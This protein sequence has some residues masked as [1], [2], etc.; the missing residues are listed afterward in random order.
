MTA[1]PLNSE[2]ANL[3]KR[4][5]HRLHRSTWIVI[6][7]LTIVFVL[8]EIP[9]TLRRVIHSMGNKPSSTNL[10]QFFE[11][12]WPCIFFDRKMIST[13]KYSNLSVDQFFDLEEFDEAP[14]LMAD[15]WKFGIG[16]ES[17]KFSL[18]YLIVDLFACLT[19]ILSVAGLFE[20]RRRLRTRLFQFTLRELLFITFLTA[21]VFSW[22]RTQHNQRVLEQE[23]VARL[24]KDGSLWFNKYRGPKILEKLLGRELLHDCWA[25]TECHVGVC[26]KQEY[27][28]VIS[29]MENFPHL[30]S[31]R[32]GDCG[33]E[34]AIVIDK[35]L[36]QLSTLKNLQSLDVAGSKLTDS[37]MEII[38]RFTSLKELDIRSTRITS[39]GAQCLRSTPLLE[40]LILY[41]TQIDDAANEILGGLEN[42]AELNVSGTKLT[43]KAVS[44]LGRLSRLECLDISSTKISEKGLQDLKSRL[45]ESEIVYP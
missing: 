8:V 15:S 21:A 5:W 32:F 3:S 24:E 17:R 12:G 20:W 36:S 33:D 27:E 10:T 31:I 16:F 7:L 40:K 19:I 14:W 11:H 42:L 44:H 22:W 30:E 37:G 1:T 26:E 35:W 34:E 29:C 6:F 23:I 9:G 43:D 18:F 25:F 38:S 39:R 2:A 45:S 13:D 28:R 41:D 4:P